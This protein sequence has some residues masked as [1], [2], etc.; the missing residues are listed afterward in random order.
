MEKNKNYYDR[1]MDLLTEDMEKMHESFLSAYEAEKDTKR[2][3][4]TCREYA[5]S[6]SGIGMVLSTI[7]L[8]RPKEDFP[9]MGFGLGGVKE[10]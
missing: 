9:M 10:Q 3:M 4:E 6:I 8:L 5:Q 7:S 2:R 1:L